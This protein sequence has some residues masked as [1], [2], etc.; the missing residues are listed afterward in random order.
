MSF[1]DEDRAG[2]NS[3]HRT[4]ES[5]RSLLKLEGRG[6]PSQ[7]E[8]V[9]AKSFAKP[10]CAELPVDG[11][12]IGERQTLSGNR[13]VDLLFGDCERELQLDRSLQIHSLYQRLET[14][15]QYPHRIRSGFQD[16][17]CKLAGC[18][19]RKDD[20]LREVRS[21]DLDPR[22]GND[23]IRGILNSSGNRLRTQPRRRR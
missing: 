7:G 1:A 23:S 17:R 16:G 11:V 2:Y 21:G 8:V 9:E 22:A 13:D 20:W 19:R 5:Q 14:I 3:V 4:Q 6:V 12:G 15:P 18:V 10:E